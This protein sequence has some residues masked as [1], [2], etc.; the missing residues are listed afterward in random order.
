MLITDIQ[1]RFAPVLGPLGQAYAQ[2]MRLRAKAYTRH[3]LPSWK[4]PV[5]CISVGNISWGGTGKT[6]VVAWLLDWAQQEGLVPAVLT[7][8]YGGTPPYK[9][10]P[11][12]QTSPAR[13]S[14]DEPLMLKRAFPQ[15]L[16]IVDPKRTRGGKF[17][18]THA[19]PDLLVLDD[20]F[21]HLRVRRDINLCLFSP[22][23]LESQWNRVIPSGSWRE[24]ASAINRADAFLVNNMREEDDCLEALARIK[25]P[26]RGK[27]IFFFQ[28]NAQAVVNAYT[29]ERLPR[30]NG[31]RF[32]AVT[33]VANPNK[34]INTFK[35]D[36]GQQ[37][38]RHLVY[39]DHHAFTAADWQTISQTA[40]ALQC[41]H[42][43]CTP[44]DA[45]KLAPLADN[46]LWM[47][48]LSTSFTSTGT[49]S[50]ESWL[51]ERWNIIRNHHAR[52]E[53]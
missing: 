5:P 53:A 46:R 10:Y 41:S 38:Q 16:I 50:F 35:A 21:Q 27:P 52:K 31:I 17:I 37:P 49:Q 24:D 11:V 42:I 26:G 19:M 33:G 25:L 14:G 47:P 29:G 51:H 18:C 20:G 8:G 13:E 30:L 6:P 4:P 1:T 12:L 23:D 43:I 39:P 7:R 36:L 9:P 22:Q 34:I 15:A 45:P 40:E 28:V 2:L 32:L 48:Q 44:K 3:I